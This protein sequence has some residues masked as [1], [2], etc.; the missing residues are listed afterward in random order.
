MFECRIDVTQSLFVLAVFVEMLTKV[1]IGPQKC[2]GAFFVCQ[3]KVQILVITRS[4]FVA[5]FVLQI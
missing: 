4:L 3:T 5:R 2:G 1:V